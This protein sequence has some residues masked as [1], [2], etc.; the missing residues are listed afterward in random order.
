L[1]NPFSSKEFNNENFKSV[2]AR[3]VDLR[4]VEFTG[5]KFT[6]CT[7]HEAA[8]TGCKFQQCTFVDCD[9]SMSKLKGSSFA[10]VVFKDSQLVGI[11][12]S[13][14]SIG[15]K[16]FLKPVD[17]QHCVLN[18]STFIAASLKKVAITQCVAHSVDFT[19]ADLSLSNCSRTDFAESRFYHT[20]LTGANFTG[21]TNYAISVIDNAVKKA[22]FSLP[23]AMTLLYGLDIEI[24]TENDL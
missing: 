22:K 8:L 7:F 14:T 24:T 6:R 13:D 16:S 12:W 4:G 1:D 21:A 5:C 3:H 10:E 15:K 11:N 9:F 17:F 19:D 23:E 2:D 20:N 18:Y